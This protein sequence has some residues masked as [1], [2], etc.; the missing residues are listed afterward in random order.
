MVNLKEVLRE[1]PSCTENADMLRYILGDFYPGPDWVREI[2]LVMFVFESGIAEKI[3]ECKVID[4]VKLHSFVI[5]L[6][7]A[8]GIERALAIQGIKA[9]ADAFDVT[10]DG[11]ET[12]HVQR[13]G[14]FEYEED[15]GKLKITCYIGTDQS[16]VTVPN[17]ILGKPVTTIGE[18]AFRGAR[19]KQVTIED[20][21]DLLEDGAFMNCRNLASVRL[22]ETTIAIG[23]SCFA[24][25]SSLKVE[26]YPKTL[27]SIGSFAYYGTALERVLM[28]PQVKEL[29]DGT[30]ALCKDL[31]S[32][33]LGPAIKRIGKNALSHTG[34]KNV[35]LPPKVE[36]I[37]EEAFSH[38]EIEEIALSENLKKIN[39]RAFEYTNLVEIS[40]PDKVT[41]LGSFVFEGCE[42]LQTAIMG[43]NV[44]VIGEGIFME[45]FSLTGLYLSDSIKVIPEKC[46]YK[47]VSL[48]SIHLSVQLQQIGDQAFEDC[49]SLETIEL[50]SAPSLKKMGKAC[51]KNCMYLEKAVIPPEIRVLESSLF[52][53][54]LRLKEIIPMGMLSKIKD[55]VCA[56]CRSLEKFTVP[57]G[58]TEVGPQAFAHCYKL[59]D[60]S[61]PL[62]LKTI[63]SAAFLFC[64]SLESLFIPRSVTRIYTLAF[65][66]KLQLLCAPDSYAMKYFRKMKKLN[67][68]GVGEQEEMQMEET[69]L[70][71]IELYVT[72]GIKP[73]KISDRA[74]RMQILEE[75][76]LAKVL[77]KSGLY[78]K[79]S[80]LF[81]TRRQNSPSVLCFKENRELASIDCKSL[82]LD[83][84]LANMD[85]IDYRSLCG[86]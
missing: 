61:L 27:R 31:T 75:T 57:Y 81:I 3:K 55:K 21:V 54:C 15:R 12:L 20:G 53:N 84:L 24:Y 8:Y 22:S 40:V 6:V 60:V 14:L 42:S 32:I 62:T 48:K 1:I 29:H 5:S 11:V 73:V 86:N 33:E 64:N 47:C 28:P 13:Y 77:T 52:E 46:C 10:V 51:F 79:I 19:L 49:F 44:K 16:E 17:E 80:S 63:H 43:D 39:S 83:K 18:N 58:T 68:L 78:K 4:S 70:E 72:V 66:R 76:G 25:C 74:E 23:N 59:N 56:G 36:I 71:K 82:N 2:N 30:Y 41:H 45:C 9:W 7:N 50:E 37:D 38:C 65:N 35:V 67:L 34:L 85:P 69:G 26:R